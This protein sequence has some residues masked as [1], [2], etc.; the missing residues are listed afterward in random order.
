MAETGHRPILAQVCYLQ[1]RVLRQGESAHHPRK[2]V[3]GNQMADPGILWHRRNPWT[4]HGLFSLSMSTVVLLLA[5]APEQNHRATRS[6]V[7]ER[8]RVPPPVMVAAECFR[9]AARAGHR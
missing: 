3:H 9:G 2:A 8:R 5:S 4:A 7:P 1:L 6:C